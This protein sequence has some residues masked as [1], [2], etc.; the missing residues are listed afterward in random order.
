MKRFLVLIA[1]ISVLSAGAARADP[2]IQSIPYS[3][4][5]VVDLAVSPGFAAVVELADD[6][7]VDSVVVGNSGVWEVTETGKGDRLI[8]KPLGGAVPT[9]MVVVTDRRSY[10]FLLSPSGGEQSSFVMRFTY[11]DHVTLTADKLRRVATYKLRG[12][13]ALFPILMYDDGKR[14]TVRWAANASLPA[15]FS[16]NDG[17]EAVVNARMIGRDYVIEGTANS[18]RLRHGDA[19]AIAVRRVLKNRRP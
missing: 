10:V 4:D 1:M 2:R 14:T 18:Y 13:R 6:E 19:E 9:N 17:T 11:P 16:L 5:Q 15:I 3:A 8:V 7:A 12:E